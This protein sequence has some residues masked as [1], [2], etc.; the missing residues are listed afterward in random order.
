VADSQAGAQ[1]VTAHA[2]SGF[3]TAAYIFTLNNGSTNASGIATT[4][5]LIQ[6]GST[7]IDLTAEATPAHVQALAHV[8]LGQ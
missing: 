1:Q 8:I 2:I 6:S 5:M 3:G 7:L 4:I